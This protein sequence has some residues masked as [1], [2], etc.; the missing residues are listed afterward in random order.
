MDI[1]KKIFGKNSIHLKVILLFYNNNGY[2]NN[3]TGLAN[4]LNVSH[5][6]VRKV[7]TDLVDAGILREIDIG[8][9][10]VIKA[11]ENSPYAKALFDFISTVKSIKES[12]SIEEIIEKR[13][14]E[15]YR[16]M[17]YKV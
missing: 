15:A 4:T 7:I 6:T 17:G 1:L 12:K 14:K 5:V 9:S 10:T 3:I 16:R 11:N 13:S 8:K 2:F